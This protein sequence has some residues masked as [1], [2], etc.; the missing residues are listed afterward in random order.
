MY[1]ILTTTALLLAS[2]TAAI[3]ADYQLSRAWIEMDGN[4][5]LLVDG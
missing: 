5:L 1:R 3:A 2:F 4:P